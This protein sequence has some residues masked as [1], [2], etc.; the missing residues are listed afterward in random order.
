MLHIKQLPLGDYQTNCYLVWGDQS[1]SCVVI[2]PGYDAHLILEQVALLGLT[3]EA[4]FLTHG[5]TIT[6]ENAPKLPSGSLFLS[7]HTHIPTFVEK[8]GVFYVNPGSVSIPKAGSARGFMILDTKEL[9]L[10]R[11]D[12]E[13]NILEEH[14]L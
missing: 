4:V 10:V 13:G 14:K 7:G 3:V 8:E 12:L 11:M 1:T 6:P 9:T 5:H 2:D